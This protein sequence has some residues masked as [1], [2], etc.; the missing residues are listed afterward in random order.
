MAQTG[1][2]PISLYYTTTASAAPT[3]GNLVAGELAI[4]TADGKLFYKDSSGV[5]Q[6]L[7]TKDTAAGT[8]TSITDSGNLTFTGTGNRIR[9]DFSNA[10]VASRVAFQSS[11]TNGNT[12]LGAIPNGTATASVF[13]LFSKSDIANSSI[14]QLRID[15]AAS[16]GIVS[17][18]AG[19]TG[20]NLPITF[21]LGGSERLRIDTSGN[22]G[23][24]LTSPFGRLSVSGAYGTTATAGLS[25]VSTGSTTGLLSPIAFYLQSSNWGTQ[26]QATITAQQ[27]SGTDGGSNLLFGTSASG[28]SAPSERMRITSDGNFLVGTTGATGVG[29]FTVR[30]N[31]GGAGTF[32]RLTL[33]SNGTN[34]VFDF[35]QNGTQVGRIQIAATQ[36]FYVTTSDYR[37]KENISPMIGALAKVTQLKPCTYTWK[38]NGSNGQGF[39]AHELA[40]VC[41]EAVVGEK[42]KV[43]EDGSINPQGIDTSFLVATLTAAIQ[44]QQALIENLTTRLNALEG[45]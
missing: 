34:D 5:V 27:V 18:N 21:S 31:L 16:V 10:T 29:G 3:A 37:L 15:D 4:N 39:I 17:T 36:T 20:A 24:G 45:K 33:N 7:A 23:I 44:E 25:I 6:T 38:S 2:T 19:G 41:P 28:G 30:P 42:D 11:T 32:C 1:F 26:H 35:L 9:G 13:S 8:F 40:E 22:V 14:A 43:N 12:I